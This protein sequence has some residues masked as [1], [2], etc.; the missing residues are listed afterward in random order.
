[1]KS[2][3][4]CIAILSCALFL[5]TTECKKTTQT[6]EPVENIPQVVPTDSRL[7]CN[8]PAGS[9]VDSVITGYITEVVEIDS[10]FILKAAAIRLADTGYLGAC[11]LPGDAKRNGLS[12]KISGYMISY[13][14]NKNSD[15]AA[16]PFEITSIEYLK[17]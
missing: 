5:T 13:P 9:S 2:K 14:D 11:N 1:M 16:N 7:T 15:F 8:W 17:K 6:P 3:K 12:V 4:F 10:F